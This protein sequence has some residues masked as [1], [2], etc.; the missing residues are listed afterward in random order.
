MAEFLFAYGTL[1][2]GFAP[3]AM[4]PVVA[5][6]V[7]SGAATVEGKLYD[8]GSYPG[9]ILGSGERVVFLPYT[10]ETYERSQ[11]WMRER[12]LFEDAPPAQ[13]FTSVVQ[14]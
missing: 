1:Q 4:S 14:L 8:M 9:L 10:R 2:P 3:P 11:E 12:H 6:M 5:R 7:P 13:E